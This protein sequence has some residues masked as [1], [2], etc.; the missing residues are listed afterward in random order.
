MSCVFWPGNKV[1][2][3]LVRNVSPVWLQWK[4]WQILKLKDQLKTSTEI[5]SKGQSN[6]T[7]SATFFHL[8]LGQAMQ[9]KCYRNR[10]TLLGN[11]WF[12]FG[13]KLIHVSLGR[14]VQQRAARTFL[15]VSSLWLWTVVA[16]A[17]L[18]SPG[19]E[20]I[21][22]LGGTFKVAGYCPR[23]FEASAGT[24]CFLDPSRQQKQKGKSVAF[25]PPPFLF[26]FHCT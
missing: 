19:L 1:W 3:V 24:R 4:R 17:L 13:S 25:F 7:T 6:V 23:V 10:K 8:L 16:F 5:H 11:Y 9:I 21:G 18:H 15:A 26:S 12:D 14:G 2:Q 20:C 22:S